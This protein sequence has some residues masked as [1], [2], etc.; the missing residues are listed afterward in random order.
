[1]KTIEPSFLMKTVLSGP[2]STKTNIEVLKK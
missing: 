2:L 1:M